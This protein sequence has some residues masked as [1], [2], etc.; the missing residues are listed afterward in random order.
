M[1]DVKT[2]EPAFLV[3]AAR[4]AVKRSSIRDVARQTGLSHGCVHTLLKGTTRRINGATLRKL[5]AWY[6]RDWATGGESLSPEVASYLVEQVIA[7][8]HPR[9]RAGAGLEFVSAAERIYN[10]HGVPRPAWLSAV[11]AVY[12]QGRGG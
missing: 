9:E 4:K 1:A 2:G 12:T 6:L 7:P 10:K 8:L 5:R 11:R 3:N